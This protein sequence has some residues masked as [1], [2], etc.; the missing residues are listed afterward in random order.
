MRAASLNIMKYQ[1][2]QAAKSRH[3]GKQNSS[4]AASL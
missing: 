4:I 2:Q 1:Q 3:R